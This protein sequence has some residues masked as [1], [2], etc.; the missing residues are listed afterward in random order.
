MPV[1]LHTVLCFHTAPPLQTMGA[2]AITAFVAAPL[3]EDLNSVPGLGP[4]T[5]EKLQAQGINSTH[6]LIGAFLTLRQPGFTT[7]DLADAFATLLKSFDIGGGQRNTIVT[8]IGEKAN[9]WMPGVF[10][11]AEVKEA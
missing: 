3:I 10:K 9:V 7:R 1:D 11:T 6:Q 8:A 4:A 2:D 5:A